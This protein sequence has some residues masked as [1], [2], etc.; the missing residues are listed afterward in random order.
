M[1]RKKEPAYETE[2]GVFPK[3]LKEIMEKRGENQTSLAKKITEQYV[4][5]Q[6]QTIS[7]YM[8]GQSKPD[9]ERLTAIAKVLDV[10]AD[11]LL[12]LVDTPSPDMDL[13]YI[14]EQTGLSEDTVKTL[15]KHRKTNDNDFALELIDNLLIDSVWPLWQSYARSAAR[16]WIQ[17][18]LSSAE[19]SEKQQFIEEYSATMKVFYDLLVPGEVALTTEIP[20]KSAGDFC[21]DRAVNMI[22]DIVSSTIQEYKEW[23]Q[24]FIEEARNSGTF[25]AEED[26]HFLELSKQGLTL[27]LDRFTDAEE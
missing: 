27:L 5:I 21:H 6:R 8:N 14:C 15:Q 12:G 13:K 9:T 11:W 18:E 19:M 26:K 7:L 23:E 10:S 2:N 16:Y 4:T 1:P 24:A 3:R 17:S 20:A 22:S 25:T